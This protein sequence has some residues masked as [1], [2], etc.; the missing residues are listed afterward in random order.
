MMIYGEKYKENEGNP[1]LETE[2]IFFDDIRFQLTTCLDPVSSRRAL[3][4]I[5]AL[6]RVSFLKIDGFSIFL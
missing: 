4:M 5:S 6:E 3:M 1:N 2:C